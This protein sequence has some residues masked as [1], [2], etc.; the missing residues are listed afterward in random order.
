MGVLSPMLRQIIHT[1]SLGL[2]GQI[3]AISAL[4]ANLTGVA[5]PDWNN[6]QIVGSL[7]MA[8]FAWRLLVGSH[9][10][11]FRSNTSAN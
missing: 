1:R 11:L 9:G 3:I 2:T 4:T 7:M 10:M 6:L 5:S 8:A